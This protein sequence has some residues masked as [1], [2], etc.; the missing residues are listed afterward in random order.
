MRKVVFILS[1]VL[2]ITAPTATFA[3]PS[4]YGSTGMINNPSADVLRPGQFAVGYYKFDEGNARVFDIHLAK[5][6]ELGVAR[7]NFDNNLD[8]TIVNAKFGLLSER[9]LRPGIAIGVEDIGNKMERS[10]YGVVSKA[11]PLGFRIHVG[12][13]S[14]RFD[15]TFAGLEKTF[16]PLAG[17]GAVNYFPTTTLV[18]EYDGRQMNYGARIAVVPGLKV[19]TGWRDRDY[20]VGLSYTY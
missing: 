6:I 13:G 2:L 4:M 17:V 10:V 15:G 7:F 14:G 11:L 20:Y 16:K 1:I 19:N 18:V 12:V 9:V 5:K 3:A 8:Q